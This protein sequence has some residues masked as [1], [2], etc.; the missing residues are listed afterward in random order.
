MFTLADISSGLHIWPNDTPR[1]LPGGDRIDLVFGLEWGATASEY[2]FLLRSDS[3]PEK[4]VLVR[5]PNMA[6]FL[7]QQEKIEQ[8][9]TANVNALLQAPKMRAE[10][11]SAADQQKASQDIA[12]NVR[13]TV[14]SANP[15]L[16]KEAQWCWRPKS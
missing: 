12:D 8:L 11:G 1:E 5:V 13:E 7:A 10:W 4:K 9:A 16:P 6:A 15:D 3:G 14:R 2:H